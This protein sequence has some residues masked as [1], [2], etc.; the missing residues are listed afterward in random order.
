MQERRQHRVAAGVV[1][2]GR[3]NL[4]SGSLP[5][6]ESVGTRPTRT[7]PQLIGVV[8][9]LEAR[10]VVGA[11]GHLGGQRFVQVAAQARLT[12]QQ[13]VALL[14]GDVPAA[15][16][17]LLLLAAAGGMAGDLDD[18][19]KLSVAAATWAAARLLTG[20]GATCRATSTKFPAAIAAILRTSVIPPAWITSGRT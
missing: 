17:V 9:V 15:E 2:H 5:W 12:R 4:H 6:G 14:D 7:M 13:G 10:Q 8:A 19:E 1:V 16:E 3:A 20:L 18:H 11:I